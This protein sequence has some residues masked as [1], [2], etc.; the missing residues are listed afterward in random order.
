MLLETGSEI[1]N[2]S[3]RYVMFGGL[4]QSL[5]ESLFPGC[6]GCWRRKIAEELFSFPGELVPVSFLE[7][8]VVG[9]FEI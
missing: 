5:S 9:G 2:F 7:V 1:W 8:S 3:A 4:K 6:A